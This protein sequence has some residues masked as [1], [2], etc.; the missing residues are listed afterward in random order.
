MTAGDARGDA[1]GILGALAPKRFRVVPG[2]GHLERPHGPPIALDTIVSVRV[3]A[4][5]LDMPG[6]K[7]VMVHQRDQPEMLVYVGPEAWAHQV[8]QFIE[9]AKQI[10][11]QET[12]VQDLR[13]RPDRPG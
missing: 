3:S 7:D 11:A 13:S 10:H 12:S 4:P 1:Y 2:T 5:P 6:L 9:R 8:A